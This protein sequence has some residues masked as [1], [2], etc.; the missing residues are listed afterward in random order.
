[1]TVVERLRAAGCVFAEEEAALLRVAA[2]EP[3]DL[4]RLVAARTAGT[5]LEH[6]LGWAEFCGGRVVVEPGVFAEELRPLRAPLG[7]VAVLGNHDWWYDGD[8]VRR[9]LDRA[10]IRVLENEAI[11]LQHN[12]GA[13]GKGHG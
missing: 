11:A 2:R 1:V 6:L 7:V 9:A 4:E 10:G 8:E 5:P 12:G 3:A 13:N